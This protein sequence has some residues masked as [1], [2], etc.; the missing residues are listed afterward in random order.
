MTSSLPPLTRLPRRGL[1]QVGRFWRRGRFG[2][3]F[4]RRLIFPQ[5]FERRL[6]NHAIGGKARELDL[7]DKLR[8]DPGPV[9]AF[10]RRILAAEGL[11]V[12]SRAM[13][14]LSNPPALR[15]LNPVPTLPVWTR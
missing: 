13:S 7:G 10:A 6:P 5:P 12:A 4:A 8:F 2:L 9:L 15:A 3:H 11:S 14:F 1:G